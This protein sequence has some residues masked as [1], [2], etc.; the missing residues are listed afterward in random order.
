MAQTGFSRLLA[1]GQIGNL[2]MRNRI[3]MPP[4]VTQYATDTGA[5][6]ER[7]ARYYAERAKGG[8]GLVIVEA[9]SVYSPTGKA[10][11]GGLCLDREN[12][13][14]GHSRL[15]EAVH[16]YGARI[17][18]Q[19][20]HGGRQVNPAAIA[21]Q[22]PV[23][24]SPIGRRGSPFVPREL[25]I[26]DIQELVESFAAAAERA[27]RVGYD[28]VELHG[29]HG[30]LLHQFL[31]EKTNQ[32]TDEYGGSLE[33]RVRFPLQVI[34]AVR[35]A[36]GD[37]YPVLIRM[38]AEGGYTFEEAQ[39]FA[40]TW[41]KAG[42][43]AIHVSVGGI[44]PTSNA[45]PEE[46]PSARTQGWL[47]HYAEGI[48]QKVN[49]P[50]ITVGEIRDAEFA[51]GVLEADKADFIALG[52]PLLADPEWVVKVSQGRS[53]D[54][55]RCIRCEHCRNAMDN[56]IPTSCT[57]NPT[58]GREADL[59]D[60]RPSLTFKKVLVVGGGPA[61]M[62]AARIAAF[63]G[64]KVSLYEKGEALGDGQLKLAAAA[65]H[66]GPVG[67]LRD[68]LAHELDKA[69]VDVHLKTEVDD[70]KVKREKPD[71]VVV[72]TG[73]TPL[74]PNLPGMAQGNVV[75]AHDVLAGKVDLAGKKVVVL[76]GRRTGCETAE[77]LALQGCPT[78]VVARS[79]QSGLAGGST[80]LH[81]GPLLARLARLE[82][83]FINEHDVK[84]IQSKGINL[85]DRE[86]KERFLEADAIVLSRGV[87]PSRELSDQLQ[88]EVSE[89]YLIGDG[90]E[91]RDIA[92]AMLEGAVTGQR[93]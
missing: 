87:T 4:M 74:I 88:G 84:E 83:E 65:P 91:P 68:F 19:L 12:L 51:E 89:L 50:V 71:V 61:G 73:A 60:L 23:A 77:F 43:N 49:V 70:A 15:T 67:W 90:F 17:A 45:S 82:V 8:V 48:K 27:K 78:T 14:P 44:T 55:R 9:A 30:Y 24:P 37:D 3:V 25:T 64:H 40:Q 54:I 18:V 80:I 33:N 92:S 86:G 38:S 52:R 21:P 62:E 28:A 76:G 5:V 58:L 79:R 35:K 32:R 29:A 47:V 2:T 34:Q 22:L 69:G 41:E 1:S 20:H 13:V 93:I 26:D 75:T 36:V 7:M 63:R 57:V 39:V 59:A 10:W 31:S 42:V 46:S 53:E 81:R 66:K 16:Y 56:G 85:V 11:H 72:A 6:S